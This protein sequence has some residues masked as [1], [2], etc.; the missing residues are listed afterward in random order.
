MLA[1]FFS[2]ALAIH[3][4]W[5]DEQNMQFLYMFIIDFYLDAK[6]WIN[7]RS[8][9]ENHLTIDSTDISWAAQKLSLALIDYL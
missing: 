4:L 3:Y 5:K 1:S 9:E 8:L 6:Y 7:P 2:K